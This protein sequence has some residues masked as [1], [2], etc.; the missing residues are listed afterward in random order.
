MHRR[1]SEFFRSIILLLCLSLI[2]TLSACDRNPKNDSEMTAQNNREDEPSLAEGSANGTF[3][4]TEG[5]TVSA[6]VA[7][8]SAEQ[9]QSYSAISAD[10]ILIPTLGGEAWQTYEKI[11][12]L[13]QFV[14]MEGSGILQYHPVNGDYRLF[15]PGLEQLKKGN[16]RELRAPD[17]QDGF[18][19]VDFRAQNGL[20]RCILKFGGS[21]ENGEGVFNGQH[22]YL[23]ST[24]TPVAGTPFERLEKAFAGKQGQTPFTWESILQNA[25][26]EDKGERL[27]FVLPNENGANA[28]PG[29][30]KLDGTEDHYEKLLDINQIQALFPEKRGDYNDLELIPRISVGVGQEYPSVYMLFKD[31]EQTRIL[32]FRPETDEVNLLYSMN[33]DRI[34]ITTLKGRSLLIEERVGLNGQYSLYREEQGTFIEVPAGPSD[35]KMYLSHGGEYLISVSPSEGIDMIRT[36]DGQLAG[37]FEFPEL[38]NE[39][40]DFSLFCN[41]DEYQKLFIL[42]IIDLENPRVCTGILVTDKK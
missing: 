35:R 33:S 37:H 9:E 4:W 30:Y 11:F 2:V 15:K 38:T 26:L 28:K 8:T 7:Q 18:E 42:R 24:L 16:F 41:Y 32:R 29:L 25:Y 3:A 12:E 31:M 23:D 1:T 14:F 39:L 27:Y 6:S 19:G 36:V 5:N 21:D 22:E 20:Y 17:I 34:L 10:W 13:E 40:S